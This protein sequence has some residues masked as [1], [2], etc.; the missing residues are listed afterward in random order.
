MSWQWKLRSGERGGGDGG[1]GG[2]E[3]VQFLIRVHHS[4]DG[5]YSYPVVCG[6]CRTGNAPLQVYDGGDGD[7]KILVSN[8]VNE[9]NHLLMVVVV[10]RNATSSTTTRRSSQAYVHNIL[11]I[12]VI[13]FL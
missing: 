6:S 1:D 7:W 10:M 3:D 2:G 5:T 4:I 8:H 9:F 13:L 11:A 12:R